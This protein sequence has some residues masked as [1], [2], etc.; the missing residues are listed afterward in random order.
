MTMV[1]LNILFDILREN[2]LIDFTN[3]SVQKKY[4]RVR[5]QLF[6]IQLLHHSLLYIFVCLN[7]AFINA[8]TKNLNYH[9]QRPRVD[10]VCMRS[11]CRNLN[12]SSCILESGIS[13]FTYQISYFSLDILLTYYAETEYYVYIK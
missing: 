9:I 13:S 11:A 2:P 5:V 12:N 8:K 4:F 7:R 10:C 1:R 3:R 6:C